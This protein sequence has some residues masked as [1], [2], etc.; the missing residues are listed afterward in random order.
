MIDLYSTYNR[1]NAGA[2]ALEYAMT[3]DGDPYEWGG[4]GP[5]SFDCSGLNINATKTKTRTWNTKRGT[6]SRTL[7]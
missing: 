4:I 6:R 5:N 3:K 7:N 1:G 2:E